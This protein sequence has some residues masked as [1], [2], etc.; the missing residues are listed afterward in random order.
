MEDSKAQRPA[1]AGEG[2]IVEPYVI[3][4]LAGVAFLAGMAAMHVMRD[5]QKMRRLKA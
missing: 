2:E 4:G 5:E 1:S 3:A